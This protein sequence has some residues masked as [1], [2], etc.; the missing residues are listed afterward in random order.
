MT[1]DIRAAFTQN[2]EEFDALVVEMLEE[3]EGLA[4]LYN[5]LLFAVGNKYPDET[6][7][8]TALRY[9]RVAKTPKNIGAAGD[10]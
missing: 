5:E 1:K 9:I 7:H 4:A 3:S 6:R 2:A 10:A 8:E